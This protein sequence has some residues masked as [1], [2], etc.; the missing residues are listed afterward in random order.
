MKALPEDLATKLLEAEERLPHGHGFRA[1]IEEYAKLSGIPRATLYYYFSGRDDVVQ[2]FVNDK[3]ERTAQ[4][5]EKALAARG[6]SPS[7]VRSDPS[8]RTFVEPWW[9]P[10]GR[11]SRR[12]RRAE[13]SWWRMPTSPPSRSPARS[14]W[15]RPRRS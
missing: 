2:F 10:F 3:L 1:S 15:P 5:V 12:A 6:S 8:R 4:A 7:W 11:S 9:G 13:S 14:A